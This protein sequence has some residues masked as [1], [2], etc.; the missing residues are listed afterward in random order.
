MATVNSNTGTFGSASA[1]PVITVN[2]KGLITAVTTATPSG[3]GGSLTYTTVT[4]NTTLSTSGGNFIITAACTVTLPSSGIATGTV[5]KIASSLGSNAKITIGAFY[6][7]I[8]SSPHVALT[9][10]PMDGSVWFSGAVTFIWDGSQWI[11]TY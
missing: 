11:W 5:I 4:T 1:I 6:D 9:A 2:G 3:G 7:A 8:N 10:S